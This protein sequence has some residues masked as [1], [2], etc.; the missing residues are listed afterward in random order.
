M[1][2]KHIFNSCFLFVRFKINGYPFIILALQ[3]YDVSEIH[4]PDALYWV[5]E[6]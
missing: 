5:S 2:S 4:Q 1:N 6:Y 3:E